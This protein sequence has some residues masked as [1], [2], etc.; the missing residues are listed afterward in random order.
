M[1][2]LAS[3]CTWHVR[4]GWKPLYI[5]I[6]GL[7]QFSFK[8]QNQNHKNILWLAEKNRRNLLMRNCAILWVC[9]KK[10]E[11]QAQK[12]Q[13]TRRAR[14]QRHSPGQVTGVAASIG[15]ICQRAHGLR[16]RSVWS[17][18]CSDWGN[19]TLP[20][21]NEEFPQIRKFWMLTATKQHMS[22]TSVQPKSIFSW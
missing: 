1:Q 17:P 8:L 6:H 11:N 7:H 18:W 16:K 10:M 21:V 14:W 15:H 22:I 2:R 12:I 3:D 19:R 5:I 4:S 20:T 13:W 9:H